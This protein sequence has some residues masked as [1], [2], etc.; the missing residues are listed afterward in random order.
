MLSIQSLR[1][2]KAERGIESQS[3]QTKKQ[4]QSYYS[5]IAAPSYPDGQKW[6]P[7]GRLYNVFFPGG[8]QGDL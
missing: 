8:L 1:S 2:P 3:N 6:Q 4:P 5:A 7:L